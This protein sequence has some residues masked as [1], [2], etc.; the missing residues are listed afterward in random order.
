MRPTRPQLLVLGAML[1]FS[2]M[3]FFTR[4]AGTS[5]LTVAAW[6]AILVALVFGVWAVVQSP[7]RLGALKVDPPTL[8]HGALYGLALAVASSTYVGGFA[9]TTLANAVF[10]H[11]LA[12]LAAFPL[13]WWLFKERPSA[14]GISGA[15]MAIAGVGLLSGVSLFQFSHYTH[16]RFLMGD[17]LAVLSALAYA[18]VLV[19]TRAA[20]QASTPLV[21][22]LFVAWSVA[23]LV[24]AL[25]ALVFG[26][27]SLSLPS[28]LWILGLSLLSTNLPFYLLNLG[29]REVPAGQAS[30]LSMAEVV[31]TTIMGWLVFGEVL[32]PL[33]W[34]GGALVVGGVLYALTDG[35]GASSGP[36]ASEEG[37]SDSTSNLRWFRLVLWLVL[38]NA[39]AFLAILAGTAGVE[40]LTWC[41]FA[42]ILLL[43]QGPAR[44]LVPRRARPLLQWGTVGA[45]AAVLLG[46][47]ARGGWGQAPS[48]VLT[49][50]LALAVLVVDAWLARQE[51]A[52]EREENSLVHLALVLVAAANLLGA[53]GHGG[54]LWLA[55]AAA[56]AGA[57]S[58]WFLGMDA[59]AGRAPWSVSTR[60]S[61]LR[62]AYT[63]P[64]RLATGPR[65]LGAGILVWCTG[66]F[67]TIPV[68]HRGIVEVLGRP[69][70]Q[71][72]EPG[73]LVQLPPP[74]VRV[75]EV[76]LDR[77]RRIDLVSTAS[78]LLCGD[79]SLVSVSALLHARVSDPLK[80]TYNASDPES[81]LATIGRAALVETVGRLA[82]D[83]VLT[84]GRRDV[85]ER[86]LGRTQAVADR[87]GLGMEI[88]AVHLA[89]VSVPAPVA[90]SFLDVISAD[91]EK[92]TRINQAEA[93]A[94]RVLPEAFGEAKARVLRAEGQALRMTATA[95]GEVARW[96]AQAEGDTVDPATTRMR[97]AAQALEESLA[98][99]DLVLAPRGRRVWIGNDPA[100]PVVPPGSVA[101]EKGGSKK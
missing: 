52:E 45:A 15:V 19:S 67:H 100:V 81:E 77:I 95:E 97:L 46:F 42:A 37:T 10:F 91:E 34:M 58:A 72:S 75:V 59:L 28:F 56:V 9:F 22:T 54:S 70:E 92:R 27:L 47:G 68:G 94:A 16:G 85:E 80:Y 101:V 17:A 13:A 8:R 3:A 5:P 62:R 36:E 71:A 93:Y 76:D 18:A 23:A 2:S 79:Q 21:P 40:M 1:A 50:A 61:Y 30:V 83:Q 20:R 90:A 63:F 53:S 55:P 43:G 39:G 31:F 57:S 86:V 26:S 12:P 64:H 89:S 38:L 25:L 99:R 60:A 35:Q 4:H 96:R 78:P 11:N 84:E 65:L 98:G 51:P 32:S 73:L 24:L 82:V 87:L 69:L 44:S 29:M 6:R 14:Q 41:A 74:L 48:S 66:A 7:R 33:G 88:L 49:A